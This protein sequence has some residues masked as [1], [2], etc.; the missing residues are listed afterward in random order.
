M[1][2]ELK[3]VDLR[4]EFFG[5]LAI[6]FIFTIYGYYYGMT[7][8]EI[9]RELISIFRQILSVEFIPYGVKIFIVVIV[10]NLLKTFLS[11]VLGYTIIYPL[12]FASFNGFILGLFL[13]GAGRDAGTISALI[14]ILPHGII[15]IPTAIFSAAIGLKLGIDYFTRKKFNLTM[16]LN[17]YRRAV[18]PLI[19]VAAFIEAFITPLITS[20]VSF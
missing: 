8:P 18:I 15:E 7:H 3:A 17:I 6:F 2:K 16:G 14:S 19:L 11:V 10:N 9:Y 4:S 13:E 20:I 1:K 12:I 5:L